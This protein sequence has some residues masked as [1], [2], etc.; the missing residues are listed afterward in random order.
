MWSAVLFGAVAALFVTNTIVTLVQLRELWKLR[1]H[2]G[3]VPPV[4]LPNI[5]L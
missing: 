1:W 5:P 3:W 2:E 4:P